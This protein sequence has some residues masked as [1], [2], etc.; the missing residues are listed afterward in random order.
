MDQQHGRRWREYRTTTGRR[1]VRE[2]IDQIRAQNPREAA[3]ILATMNE[4]ARL[5]TAAA[6][7][8]RGDLWEVRAT[9]DRRIFRILFAEEGH[10][11]QVLLALE[12]FTKTTR[13]TPPDTIALAE[14]RLRDW[15]QR[16]RA[17]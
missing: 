17:C 5:G 2:F 7:H 10:Y 4:V 3:R 8:L 12:G 6:R 16:G 9:G 15:R 13:R 11:G 14:E 1:P